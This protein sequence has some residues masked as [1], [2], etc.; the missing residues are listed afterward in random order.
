MAIPFSKK[1]EILGD[2]YAIKV[3]N[4]TLEGDSY[5]EFITYNDISLPT[6][7]FVNIGV[8]E[9]SGITEVGQGWIDETW[10]MFADAVGFG[11]TEFD[12]LSQILDWIAEQ[13]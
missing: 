12:G 10:Q 2:Y 13:K 5:D 6:C 11:D 7:Y 1:V 4:N 8:I 3:I 9:E